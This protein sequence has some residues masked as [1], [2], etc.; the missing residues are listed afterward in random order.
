MPKK[1]DVKEVESLEKK[2][3]FVCAGAILEC[4]FGTLKSTLR[5]DK[6]HGVYAG[7]GNP[8]AN[9]SDSEPKTNIKPFG[10]CFAIQPQV[11]CE[12]QIET[13]WLKGHS[14]VIFGNDKAL[15]SGSTVHCMKTGRI[16]IS[17]SGQLRGQ[18]K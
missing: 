6:S 14:K 4:Q 13:K 17:T 8:F 9:V 10:I 5:M 15:L 3:R 7:N 1:K 11:K 2:Q 12:P 16:V 18:K